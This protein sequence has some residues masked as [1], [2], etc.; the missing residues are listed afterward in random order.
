MAVF[1]AFSDLTVQSSAQ[2]L[3][4]SSAA[5]VIRQGFLHHGRIREMASPGRLSRGLNGF[6]GPRNQG[7][8]FFAKCS[9]QWCLHAS[10]ILIHH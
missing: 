7:L 5:H 9:F 2:A 10:D 1:P 8:F 3:P 6:F 4:G